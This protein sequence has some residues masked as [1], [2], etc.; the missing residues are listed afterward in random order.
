MSP[1]E[2]C[3]HIHSYRLR[4]EQLLTRCVD[5]LDSE[6]ELALACKYSLQTPGKRLRPIMLL[7][8]AD[9]LGATWSVDKA[10]AAVEMFH[11]ASLIADDLPCMDNDDV[12]RGQ[13]TVHKI[14]GQATA[15]IA[16]YVLISEGY[17]AIYENTKILSLHGID[18]AE[19]R[20]LLAIENVATNA[21]IEGASGGQYMDIKLEN[22]TLEQLI[23]AIGKKTSSIF[24][25]SA[26][27]GW[28]F[29]AGSLSQLGDV[30]KFAYHLGMAFQI[31]DDLEDL[32]Q[33]SHRNPINYAGMVGPARAIHQVKEHLVEV[34]NL[35][36][37]L[38]LYTP[39]MQA[40]VQLLRL[41]LQP[42][43]H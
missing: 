26:V 14:Y 23:E 30:K 41:K 38:Q 35:L 7:A 39:I 11:C 43:S 33:D 13:P 4:V 9:A 29:G 5:H 15:I 25:I 19:K 31:L 21:G 18:E 17:K 20:G 40:L 42:S 16:T 1:E 2:A 10:A 6:N 34:D 22:P 3:Q 28:L 12:R 24:E 37:S 27:L 8:I 36:K 32:T